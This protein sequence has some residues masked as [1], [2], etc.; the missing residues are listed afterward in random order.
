MA[1][2]TASDLYVCGGAGANGRDPAGPIACA[3]FAHRSGH[4]SFQ[5]TYYPSGGI[6][7]VLLIGDTA[8]DGQDIG[9]ATDPVLRPEI[10]PDD[11]G[12]KRGC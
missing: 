3:P 10:A 2:P 9:K 4:P 6:G 12:L 8:S 11:E 1:G 7:L 5:R